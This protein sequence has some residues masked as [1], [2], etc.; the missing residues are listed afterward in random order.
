MTELGC[1]SP[2][3][4][5]LAKRQDI[6]AWE[7][8]M[9]G[10]ISRHFFD[11]KHECLTLG[12]HRIDAEQWT[13]WVVATEVATKVCQRKENRGV[14]GRTQLKRRQ[15]RPTRERLRIIDVEKGINSD[16]RAC[17]VFRRRGARDSSHSSTAIN[18]SSKRKSLCRTSGVM[19]R[20]S[21]RY[22]PGVNNVAH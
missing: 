1:M 9:E 20:T 15:Q 5:S 14:R 11:I 2:H 4:T 19:I 17:T 6:I 16:R 18:T 10:R 22:K 12:K 21:K 13:Y 8:F 3:M 7:N